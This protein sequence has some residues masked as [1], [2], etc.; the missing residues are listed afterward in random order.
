[1]RTILISNGKKNPQT[2][3]PIEIARAIKKRKRR[4]VFLHRDDLNELLR[5]DLAILQTQHAQN[6]HRTFLL[7]NAMWALKFCCKRKT[8]NILI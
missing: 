7:Q 4:P 5:H 3:G 8:E 1:M 2:K 6:F